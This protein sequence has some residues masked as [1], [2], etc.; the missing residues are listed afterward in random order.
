MP[1]MQRRALIVDDEPATC[2]LIEKVLGS[3]GIDSLILNNSTEAPHILR[4]GKFE[5]VFLDFDMPFPDGAELT[6]SDARG[7]V[8]S[9]DS[10]GL[11][12]R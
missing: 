1:H 3:I 5:V 4:Q 8:Q 10:R 11:G 2:E 9:Y 7:R 12:Q 6:A